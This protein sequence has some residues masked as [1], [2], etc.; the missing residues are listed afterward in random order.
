MVQDQGFK[1]LAC[2]QSEVIFGYLGLAATNVFVPS[3][4]FNVGGYRTR[5]YLCVQCGNISQYVPQ[6]RLDKLRERFHQDSEDQ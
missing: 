2:G 5:A 1:C 6:D 4:V 3:G